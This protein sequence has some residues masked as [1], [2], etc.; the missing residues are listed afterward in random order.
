MIKIIVAST[1]AGVIGINNK[2]PW[3]IPKEIEIFKQKTLGHTVVMGR[4]TY[5]SLPNSVRPLPDREN[6]V[7]SRS[8]FN[9]Y[10]DSVKVYSD[11]HEYLSSVPKE[12][13]VW[14]IGGESIYKESLEFA[15]EIHHTTIPMELNGDSFF[16]FSNHA[17]K[18]KVTEDHCYYEKG[19]LLFNIDVYV[20]R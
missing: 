3:Y 9:P 6:I 18:F 7:I 5:E 20:R 17:N 11:L 15:D 8:G 14:I 13:E 2:L 10:N 1:Y 12:K 16:D 19:A 4:K